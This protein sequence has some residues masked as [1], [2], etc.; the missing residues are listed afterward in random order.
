MLVRNVVLD[1]ISDDY[2]GLWEVLWRLHTVY[3]ESSES[4]LKTR[5]IRELLAMLEEDRVS[6]YQQPTQEASLRLLEPERARAAIQ[7]AANWQAPY[8]L[9]DSV[10]VVSTPDADD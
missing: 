1:L 10:V 6:V 8:S 7:E 4:E 3:P 2:Y 5:A 9:T